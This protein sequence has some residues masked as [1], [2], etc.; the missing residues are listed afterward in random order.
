MTGDLLSLLALSE[1]RQVGEYGRME[2]RLREGVPVER[3]VLPDTDRH[4]RKELV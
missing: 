2:V 3:D 4:L 1:A